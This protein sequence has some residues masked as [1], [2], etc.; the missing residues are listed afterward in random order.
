MG[1]ELWT[2]IMLL[3]GYVFMGYLI[4][5]LLIRQ[6]QLIFPSFGVFGVLLLLMFTIQREV[7]IKILRRYAG[8]KVLTGTLDE[9]E[10]MGEIVEFK[11]MKIVKFD[12]L[13]EAEKEKI[14][15]L[16]TKEKE[17]INEL[18]RKENVKYII[19]KKEAKKIE[20]KTEKS[21]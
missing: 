3:A 5:I 12:A 17:L 10:D 1:T 6:E 16:I 4:F 21:K 13:T 11:V 9:E 14:K 8:M 19:D 15:T 2:N 7:K 20:D 18:D